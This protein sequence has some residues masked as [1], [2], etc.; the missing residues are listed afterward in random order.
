[1]EKNI[2]Q[3]LCELQVLFNNNIQNET[4][5]YLFNKEISIIYKFDNKHII[6]FIINNELDYYTKYISNTNTLQFYND[7]KLLCKTTF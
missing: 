4:V 1:M 6:N 7:L 2:K 3:K 5:K